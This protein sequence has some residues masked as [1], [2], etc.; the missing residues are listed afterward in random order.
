MSTRQFLARTV[1]FLFII[2]SGLQVGAAIYEVTV[3]T[4]LWS[5]APPESVMH[6]NPVPE[7]AINPGS[8]WRFSTP[9]YSLCGLLMLI[10]A[11]AMP[12]RSRVLTLVAGSVALLA[13]LA[14]IFYFVPGLIKLIVNRGADLGG[15]EITQMVHSWVKWNWVRLGAISLAWVMAIQA[16]SG[17]HGEKLK[18]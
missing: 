9:L 10:G 17:W 8:F 4:P 12:P 18:H 11:W 3:I 7:Y 6:W 5:G 2:T 16:L 1:L 14:T 13:F 15:E